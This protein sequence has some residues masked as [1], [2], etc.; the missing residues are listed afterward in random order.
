MENNLPRVSVVMPAYNVEDYVEQAVLSVL[1]QTYKDLEL[2]VIDDGSTDNT[3]A[4]IEG[5]ASN[6]PRLRIVCQKNA[7]RPSIARNRGVE[8]A[9]GEYLTFLDSDDF[10][11]P[12]RVEKLVAGLDKHL[13]WV[14]AFH[15][16]KLVAPNGSDLGQVY[17]ADA[18]FLIK[19]ADWLSDLG[20][21]W[22]ECDRR[23][24]VFMSL[25]YA[26]ISTQ[27]IMIARSRIPDADLSFDPRFVICEDTDLWI[28]V[29]MCGRLGFLNEILSGYRQL[30]TSITRDR[31]RFASQSVAFHQ[32]NLQRMEPILTPEE[33]RSYEKKLARYI[34]NLAFV[35][36]DL[37]DLPSARAAYRHAYRIDGGFGDLISQAK[38]WIPQP[39]L[40]FLREKS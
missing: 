26:A 19:S 34:R 6:D 33:K 5:I 23:F 39:I 25:C 12:V 15:D 14:A 21:G 40:Q 24:F 37:Y 8:I 2:I 27:S 17:L 1:D 36:Y 38:T 10:W 31:L 30:G 35:H 28:R 18:G 29:A 16:L 20:D 7:G 13:D 32:H 11:L 22:L 3:L 9:R 4:I